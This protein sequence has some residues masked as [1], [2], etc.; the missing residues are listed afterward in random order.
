MWVFKWDE[1]RSIVLS[2]HVL[3]GWKQVQ[4]VF[5]FILHID[6][7]F[8]ESGGRLCLCNRVLSGKMLPLPCT[9]VI[10]VGVCFKSVV[11]SFLCIHIYLM[12]TTSYGSA[13]VFRWL[14]G[15][16]DC[17]LLVYH[18]LSSLFAECYYDLVHIRGGRRTSRKKKY[19]LETGKNK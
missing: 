6:H 2:S 5:W 13:F 18:L 19:F 17:L 8:K 4:H 15:S 1:G 9:G 11:S 7:V 3:T 12:H 14:S 10:C 16:E